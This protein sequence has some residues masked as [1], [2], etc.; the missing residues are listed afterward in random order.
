MGDGL[1][2]CIDKIRKPVQAGT[3]SAPGWFKRTFVREAH[4]MARYTKSTNFVCLAAALAFVIPAAPARAA[5]YTGTELYE[6]CTVQRGAKT[7]VESTYECISY[8]TG[9][10]DAFNTIRRSNKLQSCIPEDVTIGQLR[11]ATVAYLDANPKKRG[12]T[13]SALIFAA[14]REAWPCGG[15]KK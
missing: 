11:Q 6:V 9:T 2:G 7:Y 1:C 3:E 8:I 12:E 10:I 15:K 4:H 14:T 5:F 13:G